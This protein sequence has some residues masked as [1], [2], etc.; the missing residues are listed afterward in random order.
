MTIHFSSTSQQH[1]WYTPHQS[2]FPCHHNMSQTNSC[3]SNNSI[4]ID[5]NSSSG[6]E[7]KFTRARAR[8]SRSL[9]KYWM[10]YKIKDGKISILC[11]VRWKLYEGTKQTTEH[12]YLEIKYPKL[13]EPKSFVILFCKSLNLL[14]GRSS[15]GKI[16]KTFNF[17]SH[18][19]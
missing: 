18:I 14:Y 10:K 1:Y 4:S 16:T 13:F 2:A 7:N 6:V 5:G 17:V 11:N 9:E 3:H 15:V 8:A 19:M 12:K